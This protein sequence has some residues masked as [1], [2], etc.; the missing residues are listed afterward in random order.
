MAPRARPVS[1]ITGNAGRGD[2]ALTAIAAPARGRPRRM[3]LCPPFAV[4]PR[5][6]RTVAPTGGGV[7]PP[8]PPCGPER[9]DLREI[10]ASLHDCCRDWNTTRGATPKA[11]PAL[12]RPPRAGEQAWQ[13]MVSG[14]EC[15]WPRDAPQASF[16]PSSPAL[17]RLPPDARARVVGRISGPAQVFAVSPSLAPGRAYS[18]LSW[19]QFRVL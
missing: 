11:C 3:L 15:C 7:I 9:P 6:A 14:A 13:P 19:S 12:S 16:A 8:D 18:L 2:T 10:N 1:A 4:G 5:L 17:D